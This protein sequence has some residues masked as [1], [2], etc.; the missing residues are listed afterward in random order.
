[1]SHP[2]AKILARTTSGPM[3]VPSVSA[4]PRQPQERRYDEW[5]FSMK[6]MKE[7]HQQLQDDSELEDD[8]SLEV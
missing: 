2:I 6:G 4:P 8:D 1:M 7:Q 5:Q 3:A